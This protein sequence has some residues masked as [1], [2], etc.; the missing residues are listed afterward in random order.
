[1][2][3]VKNGTLGIGRKSFGDATYRTTRGRTIAAKRIQ[4]NKSNTTMQS[5]QRKAFSI[6]GKSGKLLSKWIDQ[7]FDKTKYGSQRN[8]FVKLNAP[9]MAW[10]K[11]NDKLGGLD[12]IGQICAAIGGDVPVYAGMGANLAESVFSQ[13]DKSLSVSLTFSKNLIVGD[14]VLIVVAQSYC[15]SVP[16]GE[17]ANLLARFTSAPIYEY[18]ITDADAGKNIIALDKEKLPGLATACAPMNTY[19]QTAIIASAAVVSGKD[20]CQCYFSALELYVDP[21]E[22]D[23]PVIE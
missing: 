17:G 11:T 21:G 14:R 19:R 5:D 23:R 2:G 12:Y 22:D 9:V 18:V 6:M 16:N 20:A 1:M 10:L 4:E 3:I 13:E 8:H 15:K 7:T